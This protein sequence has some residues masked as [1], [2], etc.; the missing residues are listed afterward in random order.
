MINIAPG[1]GRGSIEQECKA[2]TY[3]I[4]VGSSKADANIAQACRCLGHAADKLIAVYRPFIYAETKVC[5]IDVLHKGSP[6]WM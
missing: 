3:P 1:C 5:N 4:K 6:S 2:E